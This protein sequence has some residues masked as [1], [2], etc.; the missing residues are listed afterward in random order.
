MFAPYQWPVPP[1]SSSAWAGQQAG[2]QA[3]PRVRQ[4]T[5]SAAAWGEHSAAL[6]QPAANATTIHGGCLC[7]Q[8]ATALAPHHPNAALP[9][10]PA[11]VGAAGN[12][13]CLLQRSPNLRTVHLL[14]KQGARAA[15]KTTQLCDSNTAQGARSQAGPPDNHVLLRWRHAR[16][17]PLTCPD[18]RVCRLC[19]CSSQGCWQLV[20]LAGR[21]QGLA[22]AGHQ[23]LGVLI[24]L[25]VQGVQAPAGIRDTYISAAGHDAIGQQ[26]TAAGHS[27]AC[28]CAGSAGTWRMYGISAAGRAACGQQRGDRLPCPAQLRR[29]RP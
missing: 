6:L 29:L 3:A 23:L 18:W 16:R 15:T 28:M 26:R 12:D 14:A 5:T 7:N 25:D 13:A 11:S 19:P 2:T 21:L 22:S 1:H 8:A 20:Q 10:G 17:L 27:G 9:V 4:V 24:Q